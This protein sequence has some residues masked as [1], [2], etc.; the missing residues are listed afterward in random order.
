[1]TMALR[2]PLYSL[3]LLASSRLVDWICAERDRELSLPFA[4][5]AVII[6]LFSGLF[7]AL[8]IR[9]GDVTLAQLPEALPLIGGPLTAEALLSGMANGLL[10]LTLLSLFVTFNRVVTGERLIRLAPRAFQDLGI[11]TLVALTYVPETARQVQRIREA[12]A[13]RGQGIEGLRDWQPLVIP[14]LIGGLERAMSLAEAMVARGFGATERAPWS[15]RYLAWLTLATGLTFGGWVA[16]L[17]WGMAGWVVMGAGVAMLAGAIWLAGRRVVVTRYR[18]RPWR[19]AD[20]AIAFASL[21]PLLLLVLPDE[22]IDA[23]SLSFSF[24]NA[25]DWPPFE[26][27]IGALLFLYLCPAVYDLLIAAGPSEAFHDNHR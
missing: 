5:I 7:N 18:Q 15:Q 14:L 10:I 19:T 9:V 22:L 3:I 26:P 12:Q 17:W 24:L 8:F 27:A 25:F 11:V 2:N 16:A 1:M 20:S 13:V 23:S 4:R 21:A 6:L